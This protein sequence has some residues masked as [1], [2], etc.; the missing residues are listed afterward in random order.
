MKHLLRATTA[1]LIVISLAAC[2]NNNSDK[3]TDTAK[4][5]DHSKME[6]TDNTANASPVLK[7]GKLNAVYQHYVHLTTALTNND[8][9]EAKIAANAI[10][11]GAK[12]VEGASGIAASSSKIANASNIEIQRASYAVLSKDME[13]LIKKEGLASG[14]L[15]VDFCPM[16]LN[17]K[18]A[19]WIT[20]NK[21][22]RNPYFGDKM[23]T[24]GEVQETI[25]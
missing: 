18:G 10:E 6:Q 22:I 17:D 5:H 1:F 21:E 16:A 7:N 25:K 9:A 2:S 3:K 4:G 19:T 23:L 15:Y 11:A 12:E 13:S 14:E 20:A 24:C 8:M